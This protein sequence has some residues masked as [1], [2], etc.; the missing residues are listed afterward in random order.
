MSFFKKILISAE[1]SSKIE[2][3]VPEHPAD[4]R[5]RLQT[6]EEFC[7]DVSPER[8]GDINGWE[9]SDTSREHIDFLQ[10]F[11]LP[12]ARTYSWQSGLSPLTEEESQKCHWLFPLKKYYYSNHNHFSFNNTLF[13]FFPSLLQL[14]SKFPSSARYFSPIDNLKAD[15]IFVSRKPIQWREHR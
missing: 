1:M 12:S 8:H 7:E 11:L 2:V 14:L 4:K 13:F 5:S 6:W 3:M 10:V 15:S 9:S